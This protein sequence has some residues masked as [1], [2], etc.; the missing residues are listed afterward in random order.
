[1]PG[2]CHGIGSSSADGGRAKKPAAGKEGTVGRGPLRTAGT[3]LA[4]YC[5]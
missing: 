4:L 3:M 1:M 2:G 5:I